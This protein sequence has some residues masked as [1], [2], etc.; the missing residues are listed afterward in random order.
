MGH[1]SITSGEES[2]RLFLGELRQYKHFNNFRLWATCG[3]GFLSV[4]IDNASALWEVAPDGLS[5]GLGIESGSEKNI[6]WFAALRYLHFGKKQTTVEIYNHPNLFTDNLGTTN[7][8]AFVLSLG[9]R[10]KY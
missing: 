2:Y 6:G 5:L 10:F 4:K 7:L 1:L 9:I 3:Y 8:S